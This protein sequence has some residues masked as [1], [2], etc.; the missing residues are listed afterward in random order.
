MSTTTTTTTPAAAADTLAATAKTATTALISSVEG[1]IKVAETT[2]LT[3]LQKHERIILVF[4]V[5]LAASWFGNHWL[6]NTAAKDKQA[7]TVAA[8]QLVG[9]AHRRNRQQS[10]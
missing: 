10:P 9:K 3:W 5:L 8:Q 4:L 6:N 2:A 1:D 7:A